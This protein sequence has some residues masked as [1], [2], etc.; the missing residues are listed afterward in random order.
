MGNC[1]RFYF[2]APLAL[3]LASCGTITSTGYN[4]RPEVHGHRGC[5]G[6]L[7]ENTI[8][9]FEKALELGCDQLEMDVVITGDSQVLV[10]HEPWME[11]RICRTPTG[12]SITEAEAHGFNIY[13]MTLAEVQA[14][15]CGS[16]PHPDFPDQENSRMQKP[17]L[18]EVVEAVEEKAMELGAGG[19]GYNI[20]IKSEAPLYG[21][22]QPEPERFVELVLAQIDALGLEGR[23]VIQ[24]FDPAILEAV[25]RANREL[26]VALLVDNTDGLSK[27]LARLSFSP[28]YYSP[29]FTLVDK[30][31]VKDLSDRGIG[32]LVWTVNAKSDMRKMIKLGA[33]GIITDRP[34]KLIA[35]LDEEE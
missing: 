21:T 18:R 32:L 15:D 27:N 1:E 35:V 9:A 17:T 3:L 19:I 4:V 29:A 34:D 28:A 7:P 11:H 33:A 12:D 31:L 25:H 14:F 2:A 13:R 30:Q 23:C 6:L 20:E 24:S 22:Y 10:S 5:R 26:P 16:S 8:A